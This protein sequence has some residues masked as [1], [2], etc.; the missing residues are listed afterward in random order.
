ML[1]YDILYALTVLLTGPW[2]LLSRVRRGKWRTDWRSRFGHAD[3]PSPGPTKT[4]LLHGV[5]VGEVSAARSLV[6]ELTAEPGTRVRVVISA[7]TDTGIARAR[8]LF[9]SDH[10]VVRFPFDFSWMIRR[11]LDSVQPDVVVLME[12]EVWPN[13]ITECQ[14]RAIPVCVVNGRLSQSSYRNYRRFNAFVSPLFRPLSMVGVQTEEY[15]ARFVALGVPPNRVRIT[16]TMKWDNL[17]IQS[18]VPGADELASALGIDRSS[19][20]VVA[21]STG[22]GEERMLIDSRPAGVQLLLVP[23]KPER[24]EGVAALDPHM[25]RWTERH[26]G[27]KREA[28]SEVFLLDTMG[29]LERA[30]ALADVAV[31]GRSF[32]PLG[33]SDPIPSVALGK[34]TVLGPHH[35]NFKHVVEELESRGGLVVTANPMAEVSRLLDDSGARK[36]MA[37]RGR[38]VIRAHQGASRRTAELV[39]EQLR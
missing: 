9:G 23:R 1:R 26:T 34:P 6:D 14:R 29:E 21:G 2:L 37:S 38:E 15:A 12:L 35:E 19:P 17:E 25:V 30:Y 39:L 24:F 16:D 36:R 4:I 28:E 10:T 8:V 11:F 7:T 31:V 33:G 20:L 27:R 5:S 18:S 3:L 22:P 13:F 32:V